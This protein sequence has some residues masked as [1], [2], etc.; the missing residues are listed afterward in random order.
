MRNQ[1]DTTDTSTDT[2]AETPQ[3]SLLDSMEIKMVRK[4]RTI[5]LTELPT[6]AKLA[7]PDPLDSMVDSIRVQGIVYP[8]I[9]VDDPKGGY[10][11]IDGRRRIKAARKA[12]HTEVPAF[13][14]E[15]D[16]VGRAAM[17]LVLQ[18]Q[19]RANAVSE[20][21]AITELIAAGFTDFKDIAK[22]TGIP[23]ARISQRM[24]LGS[25]PK[26]L[27]N[28]LK[29]GKITDT[30]AQKAAVLTAEQQA[31][32]VAILNEK[33]ALTSTDVADLRRVDVSA[34]TAALPSELWAA[35]AATPSSTFKGSDL[36]VIREVLTYLQ[37]SDN[38]F[39]TTPLGQKFAALAGAAA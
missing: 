19:R 21:E 7:G 16:A 34:A 2:P 23:L 28:A 27:M 14:F 4:A 9:L 11:V 24:K 1:T 32:A 10:R 6:N 22:S 38:F 31:K 20:Y 18:M 3:P 39:T 15:T 30:V 8:V 25:L 5:N 26:P 12:E 13:V 36:E 17:T 33:K 37:E 29:A 35:P